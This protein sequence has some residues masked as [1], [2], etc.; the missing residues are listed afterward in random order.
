MNEPRKKPDGNG[1]SRL[2]KAL[3]MLTGLALGVLFSLPYF[4]LREEISRVPAL[5]YA[6]ILAGCAI[7]NGSLFLPT[8]STLI[9]LAASATLNPLLCVLAGGIGAGLGEQV[10]YFCGRVGLSWIERD[11]EIENGA[12]LWLKKTVC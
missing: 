5:G 9:V 3:L 12:L 6:G 4:L 7:S 11:R 10:S 8:S 1:V 2:K